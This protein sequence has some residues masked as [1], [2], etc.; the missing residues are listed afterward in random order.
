MAPSGVGFL[1]AQWSWSC[2]RIPQPQALPLSGQLPAALA[3]SSLPS[4]HCVAPYSQELLHAASTGAIID[5]RVRLRA[6]DYVNL[7]HNAVQLTALLIAI[8]FPK[9]YMYARHWLFFL[10]SASVVVG[11]VL[12][13]KW[14]PPDLLPLVGA[15][16][17][18]RAKGRSMVA[19]L[20]WKPIF[21]LRVRLGLE[22]RLVRLGLKVRRRVPAAQVHRVSRKTMH[23]YALTLN[24]ESHFHVEPGLHG[25]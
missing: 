23:P 2:D 15:A 17:L 13:V 8:L 20:V 4:F 19:Y 22:V 1:T 3:D 12:S 7:T 16:C 21:L 5:P 9:I 14:T 24:I 25:I 18:S 11:T 6:G 10:V